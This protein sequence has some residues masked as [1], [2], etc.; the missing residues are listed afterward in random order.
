MKRQEKMWMEPIPPSI[1][2]LQNICTRNILRYAIWIV[3]KIWG[4]KVCE[5]QSFPTIRTIWPKNAGHGSGRK[6]M[7]INHPISEQIPQ[8]RILWKEAFGDSDNFLD[9][10]YSTAFSP[11]R[12]LCA[13]IGC[14]LAAMAYWFDC[15]DYAYIYAVDLHRTCDLYHNV[16]LSVYGL[17]GYG[18]SVLGADLDLHLGHLKLEF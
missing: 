7:N 11:E 4:W 17:G 13:T 8:L 6:A 12:C 9:I 18:V 1:K 2:H 10:F 3:K 14:E 15:E 5:K 16:L